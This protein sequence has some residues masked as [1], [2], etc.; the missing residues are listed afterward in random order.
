MTNTAANFLGAAKWF[1]LIRVRYLIITYTLCT[2]HKSHR[3]FKLRLFFF[4]WNLALAEARLT[5]KV[6]AEFAHDVSMALA[7]QLLSHSLV[8]LLHVDGEGCGSAW[9]CGSKQHQLPGAECA[10]KPLRVQWLGVPSD[11]GKHRYI[12]TIKL[13]LFTTKKKMSNHVNRSDHLYGL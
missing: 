6:S 3:K 4:S 8:V 9:I 2:D 13:S 7:N 12:M 1:H 5:G 10:H 11:T